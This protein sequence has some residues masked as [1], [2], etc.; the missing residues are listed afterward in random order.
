MAAWE[1][2]F[3]KLIPETVEIFWVDF[4][5]T[6]ITSTIQVNWW[7]FIEKY[8]PYKGMWLSE[9]VRW[10]YAPIIKFFDIVLALFIGF[11]EF[12]WEFVKILSLT[13]RLFWN[14]LAGM[15]LLGLIVLTSM[16]LF[17]VLIGKEIPL[18]LPLVVFVFELFVAFLQA[19]VFSLLV[20]VYFKLAEA[21][22]H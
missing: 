11:L 3:P 7:K 13:L 9:W 16:F 15:I 21:S 4:Y 20:L 12:I 10:W 17:K 22:H 19:L 14:I 6:V 8:I 2:M 1:G 5:Q 18:I